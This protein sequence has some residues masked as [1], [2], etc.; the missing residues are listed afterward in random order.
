MGQ[1]TEKPCPCILVSYGN[2]H[3]DGIVQCKTE[4]KSNHTEYTSKGD[5]LGNYI[6]SATDM[7]GVMLTYTLSS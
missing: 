6:K 4:F 7:Q 2:I 3:L 1:S 5:T